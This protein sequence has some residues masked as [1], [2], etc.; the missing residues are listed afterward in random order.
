ML[1]HISI[2]V[3]NPL[4]VAQALAEIWK[5]RY[6]LKFTK[7]ICAAVLLISITCAGVARA[8]NNA[9]QGVYSGGGYK[10]E[11]GNGGDYVGYDRRGRKLVILS[12]RLT[13]H[14]KTAE[15]TNKGYTY[16]LTG[17]GNSLAGNSNTVTAEDGENSTVYNKVRLTIINPQGRVIL[18][19]IM[20]RIN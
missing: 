20:N 17:I 8:E 3:E 5:G 19:Q 14:G 10:V 12:N 16:R 18:N 6:M 15:W 4:N 9:P 13:I 7:T 1:H 2:A 11:T